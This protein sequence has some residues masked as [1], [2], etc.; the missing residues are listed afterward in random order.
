MKKIKSQNGSLIKLVTILFIV[1]AIFTSFLTPISFSA[2]ASTQSQNVTPRGRVG[3]EVSVSTVLEYGQRNF[4]NYYFSNLYDNLGDN[5]ANYCVF[6]ALSMQLAF[7]DTWWNDDILSNDIPEKIS[8]NYICYDDM[9]DNSPGIYSDMPEDAYYLYNDCDIV[10]SLSCNNPGNY[11][12]DVPYGRIPIVL[13]EGL[14]HVGL[15][16]YFELEFLHNPYEPTALEFIQD[17]INQ[18]IPVFAT[19]NEHSF[20]VYAYDYETNEYFLHNGYKEGV[21]YEEGNSNY[22]RLRV[23]PDDAPFVNLFTIVPN[24]NLP[25]V[26]SNNYYYEDPVTGEI[27]YHCPCELEEHPAHLQTHTHTVRYTAE[28]HYIECSANGDIN[29]EPHTL[30]YDN[31]TQSGHSCSCE[32]G[33]SAENV[34]HEFNFGYYDAYTHSR[35]CICGYYDFVEHDV[36]NCY[37][38]NGG[39]HCME[40]ICTEGENEPHYYSFEWVEI[41]GVWYEIC[42]RCGY[43]NG[44]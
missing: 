39:W 37:E 10:Y 14:R 8:Q 31:V 38:L 1:I 12:S 34:E 21:A 16:D 9:L 13:E 40:C 24:E 4:L 30:T 29:F 15:Y 25:H 27:T 43:V 17:K 28:G 18:N 6:V 2:N 7:Y 23:L 44:T 11:S 32:C 42:S 22:A 36:T 26:C 19:A 41:D 5:P 20:V 35:D 33:Y 3:D